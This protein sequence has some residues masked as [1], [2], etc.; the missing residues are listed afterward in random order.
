MGKLKTFLTITNPLN[1]LWIP[2]FV[3]F[4]IAALTDGVCKK[5]SRIC[6]EVEKDL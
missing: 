6:K 4:V 2:V 3:G 5:T 1:I